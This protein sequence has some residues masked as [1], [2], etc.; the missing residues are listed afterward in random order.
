MSESRFTDLSKLARK[1]G[2]PK[3]ELDRIVRRLVEAYD[4]LRVYLFGSFS[5][6]VP[7][8]N[9][10]LDFCVVV[11]T[12][13]E[14]EQ[15]D[16]AHKAFYHFT[17]RYTDF[18]LCSKSQFEKRL[19]NPGTME[20]KIHREAAVLYEKPE[21]VFDENQPLCREEHEILNN[22]KNALRMAKKAIDDENPMVKE[23]LFHVQQCTEMSLKA[24]RSFH[25]HPIIKIHQ[26]GRLRRMCGKLEPKIKD[27]EGFTDGAAKR[28][29]EYYWLRYYK[30]VKIPPDLAG[31]EAEI[32]ISQRVYE[33]VKHYIET[34]E[35]PTKPT[36]VPDES[37]TEQ[38]GED[39]TS[40]ES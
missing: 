27:I 12:D 10:D 39:D 38:Y 5:W 7:H 13:E 32:A 26:L 29:A 15:R 36:V 35:P 28:I 8:W 30:D 4:P 6:G 14:A 33:F 34:T 23:C 16:K 24:F 37:M 2:V 9:S 22:A 17:R 25:L 40:S 18:Y 19:S 3:R 31:V 11:E 1:A 21:V 20:H